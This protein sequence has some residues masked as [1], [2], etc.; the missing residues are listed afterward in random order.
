MD[1]LAIFTTMLI[2]YIKRIKVERKDPTSRR[3][4]KLKCY[5]NTCSSLL[6]LSPVLRKGLLCLISSASRKARMYVV[7]VRFGNVNYSVAIERK[8]GFQ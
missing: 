2:S 6:A 3:K 8:Q 7:V 5:V 1:Y 4:I